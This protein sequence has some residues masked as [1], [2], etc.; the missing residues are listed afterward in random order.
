M[1]PLIFNTLT[2]QQAPNLRSCC[3]AL[4]TAWG[5]FF[6]TGVCYSGCL[7]FCKM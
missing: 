5:F 3:R 2:A 7:H 4:W 6:N 1:D